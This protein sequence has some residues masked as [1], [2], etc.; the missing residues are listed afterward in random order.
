MP[1]KKVRKAKL[2][3]GFRPL[4][5]DLDV[6]KAIEA[7]RESFTEMPNAI[8]RRL[9]GLDRALPA[10]PPSH[11]AVEAKDGSVAAS[12]RRE[13][14]AIVIPDGAELRAAFRGVTVT[15]AVREGIWEV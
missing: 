3:D 14:S 5:I 2:V 12:G 4:M 10:I 13:S 7:A 15:G 9:L 11:A 6:Y 1:K 8:L